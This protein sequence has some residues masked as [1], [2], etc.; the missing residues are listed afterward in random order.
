[1]RRLLSLAIALDKAANWALGGSRNETISK[2]AARAR[3]AGRPWGCRLC[4]VLNWI[5]PGHCDDSLNSD[6]K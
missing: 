2:R 4:Q 5:S 6:L 3:D 1:M